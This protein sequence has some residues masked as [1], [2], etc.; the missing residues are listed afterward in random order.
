MLLKKIRYASNYLNNQ[1]KINLNFL[2]HSKN[3]SIKN[4][5]YIWNK[6]KKI[7]EGENPQKRVQKNKYDYVDLKFGP[8][9]RSIISNSLIEVS[10]TV[11]KT[12]GPLGKNVAISERKDP[13]IITKDGVTVAKYIKF[14]SRKKN[15]GCRLLGSIAGNTNTYAG[16]GTTTSTILAAEI[17]K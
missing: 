4:F 9:A 17:V 13:I 2:L 10:S 16:D 12:F 11:A 15:L 7:K 14:S 8:E 5:C 6:M 3:Q 1:A